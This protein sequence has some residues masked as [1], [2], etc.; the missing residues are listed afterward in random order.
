MTDKTVC[1]TN[2]LR[3]KRDMNWSFGGGHLGL[4]DPQWFV[5]SLAAIFGGCGLMTGTQ[6]ADS[7]SNRQDGGQDTDAG[8]RMSMHDPDNSPGVFGRR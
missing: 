1:S 7:D 6:Q 4:S 8:C 2:D 5:G 3:L